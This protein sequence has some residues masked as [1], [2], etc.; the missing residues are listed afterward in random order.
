MTF[1][2]PT[3]NPLLSGLPPSTPAPP[4]PSSTSVSSASGP[5]DLGELERSMSFNLRGSPRP[6]VTTK[7][8]WKGKAR[9][10]GDPAEGSAEAG[11]AAAVRKGFGSDAHDHQSDAFDD[12]WE[13]RGL[14]MGGDKLPYEIW[15]YVSPWSL[16]LL[17]LGKPGREGAERN[18]SG[19]VSYCSP[20]VSWLPYAYDYRLWVV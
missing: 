7:P 14:G 10:S 5:D 3:L 11:G 19:E 4:S 6:D 9:A 2:F 18:G 8:N 20:Y 17:S 16:C 1:S 13:V 12:E 15:V